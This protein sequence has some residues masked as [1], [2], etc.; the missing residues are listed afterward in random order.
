MHVNTQV[1][2]PL[3][4]TTRMSLTISTVLEQL[5]FICNS[6][7]DYITIFINKIES[8]QRTQVP[9]INQHKNRKGEL[10]FR[11]YL[12]KQMNICSENEKESKWVISH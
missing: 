6:E 7:L 12:C 1:L 10:C 4:F 2:F 3:K 8:S 11:S 5:N 9:N